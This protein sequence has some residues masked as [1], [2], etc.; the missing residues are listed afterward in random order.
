MYANNRRIEPTQCYCLFNSKHD[1]IAGSML[2]IAK[3][4][5]KTQL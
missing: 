4:M 1:I 2:I 5:I 3:V